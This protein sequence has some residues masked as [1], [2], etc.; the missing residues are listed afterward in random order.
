MVRRY[1]AGVDRRYLI[2]GLVAGGLFAAVSTVL[3]ALKFGLIKRIPLIG[4][5]PDHLI[6]VRNERADAH[7]VA[8]EYKLGNEGMHHGPWRI[9]PGEIWGVK[10]IT[11]AG[12]L[13]LTVTVDGETKLEESHE[14]PIP[15]DGGSTVA[16]TLH[17]RGFV[18]SR[19]DSE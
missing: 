3:A 18:S 16:I 13:S 10:R 7:E 12:T 14:V 19:V 4:P 6:E 9:K 11:D 8:V 17:E 1:L 15:D 2:A 5:D